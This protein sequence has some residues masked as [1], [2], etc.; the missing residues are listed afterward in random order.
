MTS[1]ALHLPSFPLKEEPV[2]NKIRDRIAEHVGV[3][4]GYIDDESDLSEDF[5]LDL[6]DVMELLILLEDIFLDGR[7]T[8]E[9]DE[10]EVVGDLVRHIARHRD[11]G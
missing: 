2:A 5:G 8:K 7:P 3:D 1:L 6:L 4:V 10:L 9:A 11:R